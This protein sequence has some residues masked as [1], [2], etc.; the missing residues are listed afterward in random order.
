MCPFYYWV[1]LCD[2]INTIS[3]FVST[4]GNSFGFERALTEW[5]WFNFSSLRNVTFSISD[6]LLC[7]LW[8]LKMQLWSFLFSS[9]YNLIA[10]NIERYISIIA[11]IYHKTKVRTTSPRH[12][13]ARNHYTLCGAGADSRRRGIMQPSCKIRPKK[14]GSLVAFMGSYAYWYE[15]S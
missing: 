5:N 13:N 14:D 15:V 3:S 9:S 4:F 11:P 10:L 2:R 1:Y 7:R 6:Q 8:A 12:I